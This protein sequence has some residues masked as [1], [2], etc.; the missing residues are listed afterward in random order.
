MANSFNAFLSDNESDVGPASK[1]KKN[2]KPK[3]ISKPVKSIGK[4]AAPQPVSQKATGK[5][6][7]KKEKIIEPSEIS[8]RVTKSTRGRGRAPRPGD[9]DSRNKRYFDRKSGTGRGPGM[10]KGGAGSNNWGSELEKEYNTNFTISADTEEKAPKDEKPKETEDEIPPE[11][12]KETFTLS[13][14]LNKKKE[15]RA[16]LGFEQISSASVEEVKDGKMYTKKDKS[17]LEKEDVLMSFG[18]KKEK[19][20]KEIQNRAGMRKHVPD[21]GFRTKNPDR[22]KG[23]ER[24]N[25]RG[26]GGRGG[27]RG[28]GGRGGRRDRPSK[29]DVDTNDQQN[30]PQ[31]GA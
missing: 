27:F 23:G 31:L 14:F 24:R 2:T 13:E 10:K 12:E 25:F 26:R 6:P 20:K 28:R 29:V 21:L 15:K 17:T 11:P 9:T 18:G 16:G 5:K 19:T 1:V 4:P 7:F 30:F 8:H 3:V 22:E